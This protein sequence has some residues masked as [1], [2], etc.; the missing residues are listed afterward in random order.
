MFNDIVP[1]YNNVQSFIPESSL[2]SSFSEA[3]VQNNGH[4][5]S[6]SIN[7]H[8]Q[9]SC[10]KAIQI[11]DSCQ[12]QLANSID[13]SNYEFVLEQPEQYSN[14]LNQDVVNQQNEENLFPDE[15]FNFDTESE[16]D[17]SVDIEVKQQSLDQ[18]DQTNTLIEEANIDTQAE[19]KIKDEI[20]LEKIEVTAKQVE[21]SAA[22]KK[23]STEEKKVSAEEKGVSVDKVKVKISNETIQRE[24][25]SIFKRF[26]GMIDAKE[27][28]PIKA[29]DFIKSLAEK[30]SINKPLKNVAL[31]FVDQQISTKVFYRK[32]AEGN[33]IPISPEEMQK[34]KEELKAKLDEFVEKHTDYF[35]AQYGIKPLPQEPELKET[36]ESEV[37]NNRIS[38]RTSH[39]QDSK[40]EI[41]VT[42]LTGNERA[43]A[44]KF[45]QEA[46]IINQIIQA[47]ANFENKIRQK[48]EQTAEKIDRI[49]RDL[50]KKEIIKEE[51]L[52]DEINREIQKQQIVKELVLKEVAF[53]QENLNGKP[54]QIQETSMKIINGELVATKSKYTKLPGHHTF[55]V[56]S[57][58]VA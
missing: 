54:I 43:S 34:I 6:L 31:E 36:K 47:L 49:V 35:N 38:H 48:D 52:K 53:K 33:L 57:K 17:F 26:E 12:E 40:V 18:L 14:T 42:V 3:K 20:T 8:I 7:Q 15:T 32:D 56:I 45:A 39:M 11:F 44:S 46:M 19:V 2:S 1:N 55:N 24:L 9:E 10:D 4:S 41:H 50:I 27:Q 30:A 25:E 13:S 21:L 58:A 22:E 5:F 37:E 28:P 23:V 51:V 29:N 16:F